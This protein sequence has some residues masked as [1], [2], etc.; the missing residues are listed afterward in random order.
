MNIVKNKTKK[1]EIDINEI[2][3]FLKLIHLEYGIKNNLEICNILK[4]EFN[5]ICTP[6]KLE[7]Y[8][9]LH[10]EMEDYEKLSRMNENNLEHLI[11]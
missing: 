2:G 5:L 7:K 3:F 8:E 10:I 1:R 11:E 9:Q 6:N 4:E